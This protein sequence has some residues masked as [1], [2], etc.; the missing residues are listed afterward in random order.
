MTQDFE[1]GK[2][3]IL[4]K[5]YAKLAYKKLINISSTKND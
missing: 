4:F 1:I 5:I 2:I 3:L